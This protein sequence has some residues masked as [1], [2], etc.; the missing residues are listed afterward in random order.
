MGFDLGANAG[1]A[2]MAYNCQVF[3]PAGELVLQSTIR[4]PQPI[5]R[6][7]LAAGYTIKLDGKRLTKAE[8]QRGDKNGN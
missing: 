1:G 3:N 8:V 2:I 5:E 6:D 7:L 4:Y